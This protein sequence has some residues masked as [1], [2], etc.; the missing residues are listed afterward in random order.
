MNSQ[1]CAESGMIENDISM[2][3]FEND[4]VCEEIIL[5]KLSLSRF[6]EGFYLRFVLLEDQSRNILISLSSKN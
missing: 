1:G 5:L 6:V 4:E 2:M 3:K